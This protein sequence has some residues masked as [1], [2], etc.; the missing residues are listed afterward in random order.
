[1]LI[2]C[3]FLSSCGSDYSSFENKAGEYSQ[4]DSEITVSETDD[5]IEEI[6]LF[7]SDQKFKKFFTN[8]SVDRNKVVTFLEKKGYKVAKSR[9]SKKTAENYFIDIYIENSG[10]MNG[11]VNGNTQFKEAIRDLFVLLKYH[12]GEN[13]I[14]VNFINSAIYPTKVEGDIVAFSKAL[15]TKTFKVGNTN[16]SNINDIFKQVLSKT[17]KDT[18]AILLSDLIY[19]I[20]G[21]ETESLLSDQKSLTKDAFL[22]KFKI[23]EKVAT[24]II[25]LNSAFN[26]NY[27]DKNNKRTML[28][29]ELRPYYITVVGTDDAMDNFSSNIKLDAKNVAGFE[30]KFNLSLRDF[31]SGIYFSVIN[32]EKDSGKFQPD[33]DENKSGSITSIKSVSINER[34][35]SKFAFTVAIDMSAIPVEESY[36]L[37]KNN[38]TVKDANYQ[39]ESITPFTKKGVRPSSLL[40]LTKINAKPTHLIVFQ[41]TTPNF[42]TL[43]FLLKKQIPKWVYETSTNDDSDIYQSENK[44]FGIKYLIEGISEAYETESKNSDYFKL[45]INIKK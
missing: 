41:S 45:K 30:D 26:G 34:N 38:Y 31:S 27:Y 11:Y 28:S 25:K 22:T 3:F 44:T 37:D 40:M 33:K 6:K 23:N 19:S 42:T 36:I 2:F 12:Y 10:S 4:S 39:I 32:T 43:H 13:N 35:S 9:E 16:E 8:G 14:S 20:G 15:N 21:G 17:S 29:G 18:I 24:S 5:L 7:E 1:M